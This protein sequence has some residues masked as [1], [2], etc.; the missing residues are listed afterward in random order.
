MLAAVFFLLP[1]LGGCPKSDSLGPSLPVLPADLAKLCDDPG[2]RAGGDVRIELAT[3]RKFL[4]LC[5]SKHRDT[6][7]FYNQ[8]RQLYEEAGKK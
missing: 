6:V 4:A 5:R 3:Q 7:K 2:V 1:M 8:V